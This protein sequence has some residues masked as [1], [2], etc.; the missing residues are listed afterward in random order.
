MSFKSLRE[1]GVSAERLGSICKRWMARVQRSVKKIFFCFKS[2]SIPFSSM[3]I[4]YVRCYACGE[5]CLWRPVAWLPVM[6]SSPTPV[7]SAGLRLRCSSCRY[8]G[9][10]SFSLPEAS[11]RGKTPWFISL[12]YCSTSTT[13]QIVCSICFWRRR[14]GFIVCNILFQRVL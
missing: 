7:S 14:L 3:L 5:E 2:R 12:I 6:V 1:F 8:T 9:C 4:W 13:T 10:Y 11:L